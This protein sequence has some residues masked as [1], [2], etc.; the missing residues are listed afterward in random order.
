MKKSDLKTGMLVKT[1]GGSYG[2]VMIN[3]ASGKDCIVSNGEGDDKSWF[4]LTS[5]EEDLK[6][7]KGKYSDNSD[8]DIVE[9]WGWSSNMKAA[10]LSTEGR[11]LLWKRID[12]K[13]ISLNDEY[14]AV[15]DFETSMIK[16]G[17]QEIP[18]SKVKELYNLLNNKS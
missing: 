17:C 5:L 2:L 11:D 14:V 12:N 1:R 3:T 8:S 7:S 18:F 4:P 15:V 13:T 9:V 16:V 10:S 6:Y